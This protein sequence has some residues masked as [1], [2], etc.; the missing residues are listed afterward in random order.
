MSRWCIVRI[1]KLK[2]TKDR[3]FDHRD[4]VAQIVRPL[5]A[6]VKDQGAETRDF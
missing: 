1:Y 6:R 3:C 4:E 5:G 2:V